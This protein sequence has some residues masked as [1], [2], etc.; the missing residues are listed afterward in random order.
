ML[1][2]ITAPL[3]GPLIVIFKTS[4][5]ETGSH[6]GIIN[7]SCQYFPKTGYSDRE[8]CAVPSPVH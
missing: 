5:G 1:T 6:I 2:D 7:T 8:V 4:Q 3:I